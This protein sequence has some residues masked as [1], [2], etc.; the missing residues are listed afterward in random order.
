MQG[1]PQQGPGNAQR[2]RARAV[3]LGK[4]LATRS[5]AKWELRGLSLAGFWE[6]TAIALA[7]ELDDRRGFLFLPIGFAAG[8]ALYFAAPREP[9]PYAGF[10]PALV[11]AGLALLARARPFG[12]HLL[13]LLA[14][15]AAG[16]AV[17]ALQ[18]QLMAHPVLGTTLNAVEIRGY[19][20]VAERRPRGSRVTL[21]VTGMERARTEAPT[22]VRVTLAGRDPPAVG[23]HVTVRATLGPPPGP[24]Y[25]GG[26]DFG[27]AI[28]LDGIGAT[29]Y[30]LG[31]P[32]LSPAPGAPPWGLSLATWLDGTRH[33]IAARIRA[34]LPG[35]DGG[36]AVALVTGLRDAVPESIEES[37][38]ISGLSHVLSISGLHMALVAST[39]FF[40]ARALLALVPGLA[41]YRPIKA[42]AALP[43]M[44]SASFYLLLSGCEVPTQRAY[45][46][47][48]LVLAGI[49]LGRPALTLR[50]L[51]V[52]ALALLMLSPRAVLDPGAQMSFAATLGLI[53][54]YERFGGLI[55]L[56][57][58]K[59]GR[60]LGLPGRYIAALVLASLAAG[61]ATAPYAAYH[62][63]RLAPLS[64][65]ANLAAMPVVSFIVMPA[66]LAGSIL[67]PFGWDDPAWRLMGWGIARMRDISELVAALPG[68]DRGVP[69]MPAASLVLVSLGLVVLCLSRTRLVLLAP[70]LA[71]AGMATSATVPR[72]D[73]LVDTEARTVAVRGRDGVLAVMGD[74]DTGV[75][76]RFAVEQWLNADGQRGRF[77][78]KDLAAA[79]A[80]DPLGCTLP[81][82][83]G[84]L[85]A[86]SRDRE[87]MEDDCRLAAVLVTPFAP[88]LDCAATV[89]HRDTRT[90][91][92]GVAGTLLPDGSLALASARPVQGT[93]PWETNAPR[94]PPS[95]R[96]PS[97]AVVNPATPGSTAPLFSAPSMSSPETAPAVDDHE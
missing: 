11:F 13:A 86:L 77:G 85:V 61:L 5:P 69:A 79:A 26:F 8:A 90:A 62:F 34:A 73:L 14:V 72:P 83:D 16:F 65:V 95:A 89:I 43:A 40:L 30:A 24:S 74:R 84:R 19:V 67:M 31:R 93:R 81:L 92:G 2:A 44:L 36:V 55:A 27:R 52:A 42:W 70:V 88:P 53:A 17:A 54:A 10:V 71:L 57:S 22:R 32:Q 48:L 58:G 50:T 78:A 80:C 7:R 51:A 33:A 45:V 47:T 97:A 68:A 60:W 63:Q 28:W 41:L 49:V 94:P 46:M 91:I 87:S 25:P 9:L 18:V 66:G 3:V 21:A 38:R 75:G 76:G 37:M 59:A 1:G 64:L 96:R 20:E 23:S 35:E 39:V 29:G 4:G 82:P 6:G 12:F 15:I 56:P